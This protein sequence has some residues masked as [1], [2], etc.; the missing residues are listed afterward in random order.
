MESYPFDDA[1][2]AANRAALSPDEHAKAEAYLDKARREYATV[3]MCLNSLSQHQPVGGKRAAFYLPGVF[4]VNMLEDLRSWQELLAASET[5]PDTILVAGH[6]NGASLED[7]LGLL[8]LRRVFFD[9]REVH[10]QVFARNTIDQALWLAKMVQRLDLTIVE[11]HVPA[12]HTV[13]SYMMML[14]KL[15]REGVHTQ[16]LLLPRARPMDP[17]KRLPMVAPFTEGRYR[18]VD[19]I[20]GEA[21]GL[22]DYTT[23][24]HAATLAQLQEHLT[25]HL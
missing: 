20:D 6:H 5:R 18:Q 23:G 14:E 19:L 1:T 13:R 7:E 22:A 21:K 12:F 9:Y 8:A 25:L 3:A 11:L 16:V 10:S 15:I 24:G 17:F 4:N 2:L